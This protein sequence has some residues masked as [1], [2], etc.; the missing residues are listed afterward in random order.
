M[1]HEFHIVRVEKVKIIRVI[2]IRV[3]TDYYLLFSNTVNEKVSAQP[4]LIMLQCTLCTLFMYILSL[5]GSQ[6][7]DSSTSSQ[8]TPHFETAEMSN[9]AE[10]VPLSEDEMETFMPEQV[11]DTIESLE[12]TDRRIINVSFFFKQIISLNNHAPMFDCNFANLIFYKEYRDGL[13]STFFLKCSMCN[14][15]LKLYSCEGPI[16][17]QVVEAGMSIGIG[18][19]N[20]EEFLATINIPF[21]SN[22]SYQK[23]HDIVS[24]GWEKVAVAE[25]RKAAEEEADHACEIGN[26]DKNGVP[27]ITVVADGCWSKRSYRSNYSALS[28]A[29]AIVGY[30]TGKVLYIGVKNKYCSICKVLDNPREHTC[31]KNFTGTSTSMES[32]ILVEGF[33]LSE[34]MY[35]VRYS[36]M[37]A[38]GDSSTYKKTLESRPYKDLTVEKIECR[39]HLLRNFCNKLKTLGSETRYPIKLRRLILSNIMKCRTSVCKAIIYRKKNN[40]KDYISLKKDIDNSIYHIFG[41]HDQCASYFCTGPKD[42]EVNRMFEIKENSDFFSQLTKVISSLSNNSRSLIRDVDSNRVEQFNAVIAKFVGGKRVNFSSR[43]SYRTRCFG[44]VVRFNAKNI[45]SKVHSHMYGK[46]ASN[47]VKRLETKREK[48]RRRNLLTKKVFRK[49]IAAPSDKDYGEDCSKPDLDPATYL[50]ES[51]K[52]LKSLER[53]EEQR[54][55]LETLTILQAE[56]GIW[57]EE[58]RKMLTASSFYNVCIRRSTTSCGPLVKSLLYSSLG[59][60][61]PSLRHGRENEKKCHKTASRTRKCCYCTLRVIR[62]RHIS[63]FR[64]NT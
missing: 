35:G 1:N 25:M 7:N 40:E 8:V 44:A 19:A 15:E 43:G 60:N 59:T 41:Q 64:S 20:T 57:L 27:L 22:K 55:E 17:N 16:N 61:I 5:D 53:T 45:H 12:I 28:G 24:T 38:D 39:N 37:I 3:T 26:V 10:T 49:P 29:A 34:E 33:R 42:Q 52:L 13:K 54:R 31:F 62:R 32:A 11:Q 30:H 36:T 9:P 18:Y 56:S 14:M 50:L 63:L 51:N 4:Y 21:M 46:P 23:H 47:L 58:R 6:F 48:Q 2:S